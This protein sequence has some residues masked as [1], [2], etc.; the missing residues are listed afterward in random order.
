ML[1]ETLQYK[2]FDI[3][4]YQDELAQDPRNEWDNFGKLSM[5]HNR[6]NLPN[7]ESIDIDEA[8]EIQS[9]NDYICLPVY[10]YDHSGITINTNGFICPWDSGQVGV[11]Y[12]SKQDI[13]NEYSCKRVTKSIRNKV[14]D[15]L[16]CEI[17]TYNDY[18]TGSV[19]YYKIDIGSYFDACGGFYGNDFANNGL[20]EYSHNAI[21]CYIEN[22]RKSKQEAIKTFIRN[23]V[24]L[25]T[26]MHELTAYTL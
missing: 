8:K 26:R 11:V 23:H 1:V 16:K 13:R 25:V 15:L 9:S 5:F 24:P 20:C 4:V 12:A 10:M 21:D 6:Y 17:Q 19:Y 2:G 3:E 22:I 7:D 18:L 14:I